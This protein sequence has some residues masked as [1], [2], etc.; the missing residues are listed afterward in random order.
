MVS[1]RPS[2]PR[3]NRVSIYDHVLAHIPEDGPGL[4]PGGT[5]LPDEAESDPS[6]VTVTF[7][8]GLIDEILERGTEVADEQA[9]ADSF[10]LIQE[11]VRHP[12]ATGPHEAL[13]ED[14]CGKEN[15]GFLDPLVSQVYHAGFGRQ[16]IRDLALGL[17]TRSSDRTPVKVGVVL[18]GLCATIQ[19]RDILLSLGRHEEFTHYVGVALTNAFEDAEPLLW[20]LAK[21]VESW[22][23]INLVRQLAST[24]SPEIKAWILK[25]GNSDDFPAQF[26]LAYIAATTGELASALSAQE[27][28]DIVYMAAG[29]ILMNLIAARTNPTLKDID[30]YAD[31]P[32]A[33]RRYLAHAA[34]KQDTL[35]GF[36]PLALIVDYLELR[37]GEEPSVLGVTERRRNRRPLPKGWT[38]K[39][40][41]RS[42]THSRWIL[43]RSAWRELIQDGLRSEDVRTFHLAEHAAK[44][45]GDDTFPMILDRIRRFP[46]DDSVWTQA[47]TRAQDIGQWDEVLQAAIERLSRHDTREVRMFPW[48]MLM[49]SQE[50]QRFPG[51]G[52]PLVRTALEGPLVIERQFGLRGLSWF[53]EDG[54]RWPTDADDVLDPM[55]RSDPDQRTRGWATDLLE[56][57]QSPGRVT[58]P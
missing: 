21:A 51:R 40:L 20:E 19:D 22:G 54:W 15:L 32:E 11:V 41:E 58:T 30:D 14:L 39:E 25:E 28:D 6:E 1:A 34:R 18:L 33:I 17:A 29:R 36:A 57:S 50:M 13:N 23:R 53:L 27:I 43:H 44:W 46:T 8:P 56:L 48:W 5:R 55:A 49:I 10:R 47:T 35:E 24:R 42:A 12:S 16:E 26:M 7:A 2:A 4:L 38:K 37:S 52:W 31:G 9:A 45:L 3:E